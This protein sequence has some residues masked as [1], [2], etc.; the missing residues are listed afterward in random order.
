MAATPSTMVEIGT[1]MPRFSLRDTVDNTTIDN[2]YFEGAN[3]ALVA[4]ICNHCPFVVHIREQL[5]ALIKE[6]QQRGIR[7]VAI[8]ANDPVSHP[9]DSPQKMSEAAKEFDFSFPYLFD[10]SQQTAKDFRAACT[11][12]IFLYDAYQRLYYRG[13]F[14]DSRPGNDRPVTGADLRNALDRLLSGEP[15]PGEQRPSIGCNIKWKPG[16]EPEYYG[17]VR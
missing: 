8:S 11:P 13:Q 7:A 16:N 5:V 1:D 4:F 6:Y 17:M 9:D 10:E 12:D 3:G 2:S 15:A 14:D